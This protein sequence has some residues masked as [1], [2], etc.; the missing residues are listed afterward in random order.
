MLVIRRKPGE[1]IIINGCIEIRVLSSN[2][3]RV[4]LGIKAP[5]EVVIL[6]E[7]VL[8]AAESNRMAAAPVGPDRLSTLAREL[9]AARPA[10]GLPAAE[11]P[12][13]F[14]STSPLPDR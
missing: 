14:S 5:T 13:N 1:A 7:E 4:Q 3:N 2:E 12:P 6:R 11:F 10:P 9:R 8:L